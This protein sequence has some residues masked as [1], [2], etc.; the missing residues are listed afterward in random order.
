MKKFL[1]IL[2]LAVVLPLSASAARLET[3][4]QFILPA[5]EQS[6]GNTYVGA[7][8]A[9]ILGQVAGDLYV[10]AGTT[11]IS[12]Q[13][14]DDLV[15][16]GGNTTITGDVGGDVR[17][18][19]GQVVI[20]GRVGGDVIVVGGALNLGGEVAGDLDFIGGVLKVADNA[21]V[22]GDLT[23][24]SDRKADISTNSYIGGKIT[25]DKTIAEKLG[26]LKDAAD[27]NS[28]KTGFLA[29]FGAWLFLKLLM[30]I[31]A[32]LV[33]FWLLS[34]PVERIIKTSFSHP[35]RSLI[36]GFAAL[37]AVPV[38]AVILLVTIIGLPL[39]LFIGLAYVVLLIAA[40]LA[41]GLVLGVW[42]DWKVM[43]RANH[44]LTWQNVLLGILVFFI[45]SYIPIFGWLVDLMLVLVV[46]GSILDLIYRR[47]RA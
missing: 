38:L 5:G 37:A 26:V 16:A 44:K 40:K 36:T 22:G 39:A 2:A 29:L 30:F 41:A 12:G 19:G 8:S 10:G 13:V 24:R 33:I 6:L 23:Y 20:T 42:L 28:L 34:E 43:K 7:G 3:G 11:V 4:D 14:T 21:K 35:W 45:L 27:R 9:S 46:F 15:I 47:W 32:G 25:Y 1:L 18:L 31:F 17:V